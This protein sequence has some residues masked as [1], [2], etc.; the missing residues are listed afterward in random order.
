MFIPVNFLGFYLS[1]MILYVFWTVPVFIIVRLILKRC[2][3]LGF[4]WNLP[5]FEVAIFFILLAL[6]VLGSYSQ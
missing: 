5:L 4:V 3:V 6:I 2:G 1:P